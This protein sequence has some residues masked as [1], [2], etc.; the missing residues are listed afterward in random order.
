MCFFRDQGWKNPKKYLVLKGTGFWGIC[1]IG[2]DVIDLILS[3]G[4]FSSEEMLEILKSGNDWDWS[5]QGDFQGLGGRGG[6]LEIR[7]M[8]VN[9]FQ[10]ESGLSI[11]QIHRR[12]MEA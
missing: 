5:T 11:K 1:F 6:A 4:K 2:A 8:V 10:R 9:E 7:R 3:Q 12:I